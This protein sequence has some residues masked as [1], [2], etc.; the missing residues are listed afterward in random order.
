M[1]VAGSV[2]AQE[3]AEDPRKDPAREPL[4]V[5]TKEAPPFS[6]QEDGAW[7]G[8]SIGLWEQAA[9]EMGLEF[10]YQE[11]TLPEI[12]DGLEAGR[13]DV[14][15][16]A[17]TVTP[18]REERVD[19]SHPLYRSGLGMA[20]STSARQGW[21]TLAKDFASLTFLKAVAGLAGLLLMMGTA[22]W[23][24]ERRAN[25]EEF[26]GSLS[27]GLW[28]GFWWAAVTMTTVGYGDKSPK[29]PGGRAVA[30]VW[31]FASLVLLGA[32]IAAFSSAITVNRLSP[33]VA[34]SEDL[35]RVQV[36]VVAGTTGEELA[37]RDQLRRVRF[38]TLGEA[39]AGLDQKR[40]DAVIYDLPILRYSL[41]NRTEGDLVTL[42]ELLTEEAYAI[43]LP[44]RSSLREDL[45][46]ALLRQLS[47]PENAEQVSFYLG[48]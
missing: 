30:L 3:V 13:F 4:V 7:K 38:E 41:Q 24:F 16:A 14:A 2:W 20:V 39:L 9:A 5:A 35:P 40:V 28:S 1:A 26:G 29:S 44:P 36:G 25:P 27:Q 8:I 46:R 48:E 19:F 43:A 12:F 21:L 47:S 42:D 33:V 15:V 45:N 34:G 18:E 32:F 17:L 23:F 10:V 6:F 22:L 11:A 37:V 31:M